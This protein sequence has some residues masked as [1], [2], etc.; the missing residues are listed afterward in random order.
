MNNDCT[1][2]KI[3][4]LQLPIPTL[5]SSSVAIGSKLIS[6]L[7]AFPI[8][9]SHYWCHADLGC[10][11]NDQSAATLQSLSQSITCM[12]FTL[13]G[14]E[15]LLCYCTTLRCVALRNAHVM[16]KM[17]NTSEVCAGI[18]LQVLKIT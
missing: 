3:L 16:R 10:S 17:I 14:V 2:T 1:V 11:V 9:R 5:L 15:T 6:C 12:M 18:L 4:C 7:P 8:N 13:L